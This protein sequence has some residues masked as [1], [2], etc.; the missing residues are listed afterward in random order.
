M[1]D[2]HNITVMQA[3][4]SGWKL[5]VDA[6]W[7]GK[8]DL[9]IL[10]GGEALSRDLAKELI[11]RASSVWNMYGPTETTVWSALYPV[12]SADNA[13][14]IGRPI[15]NTTMYVLDGGLQPVPVGVTGQ[16]YIGGEGL[17]RGYWNRPEL[18]AEKFIASPFGLG[19]AAWLYKTGDLARFR[20]D[21]NIECLGRT[22]TQVKVR[23]FRIELEEIESVLRRHPAVIDAC[24]VVREDTPGDSRLAAY[25][26]PRQQPA[27]LNEI[28]GLLKEHLPP[29]MIPVLSSLDKLPLTPNGK[30]NRS[31]L[32]Q[33][34]E[35]TLDHDTEVA[36]QFTDPLE[37]SLARIWAETLKV[38]QVSLY[39]NFFDL[40]GHSLLA[41]QM[42]ARL[43]QELGLCMKPKE[44]AFQTLGQFAASCR[45]KLQAK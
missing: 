4:P 10:C 9:K 18:N 11:A 6:G 3:T 33:L 14:P 31:A 43:E 12:Q 13:I 35:S 45:E 7:A 23:G 15:A 41:T 5:L 24:A 34:T 44:L 36:E 39:D 22:D 8:S 16:L 20:T 26:T 25:V 19:P 32:P 27:S 2:D 37:Q 1:L 38:P 30:L 40:G 21:G 17:A 42:V 28:R 29:H